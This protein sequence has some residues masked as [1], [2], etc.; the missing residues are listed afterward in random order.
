MST[1]KRRRPP[2]Q[3]I[4]AAL[5]QRTSIPKAFFRLVNPRRREPWGRRFCERRQ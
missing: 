4:L 5:G 2:A 1:Y 3:Q